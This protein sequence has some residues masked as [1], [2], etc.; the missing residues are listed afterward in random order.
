M[1]SIGSENAAYG[2]SQ[3]YEDELLSLYHRNRRG[4]RPPPGT[5]EARG[6]GSTPIVIAGIARRL[7]L[8]GEVFTPPQ[9]LWHTRLNLVAKGPLP[10][11]PL[12]QTS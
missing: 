3:Y 8:Y 7:N 5:K 1:T 12:P 10:R 11:L 9:P 6:S 4:P 2:L